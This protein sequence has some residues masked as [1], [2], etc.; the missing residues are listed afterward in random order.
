VVL[1]RIVGTDIGEFGDTPMKEL[2]SWLDGGRTVLFIDA[3]EVRGASIE[4]S[5]EWAKWLRS[6]RGL[7][8]QV[9]M[10][11]GSTLVRVTADFVRRYADLYDLMRIYTEPADFDRALLASGE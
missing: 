5:G 2:G 3:R 4:V 8:L 9:N 1:L 11:T 6:H 7:L 10:L